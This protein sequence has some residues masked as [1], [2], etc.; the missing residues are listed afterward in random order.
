MPGSS[1]KEGG[2]AGCHLRRRSTQIENT[3]TISLATICGAFSR[4]V[5]QASVAVIVSSWSGQLAQRTR[6]AGSGVHSSCGWGTQKRKPQARAGLPIP[7][8]SDRLIQSESV[9]GRAHE[10][11]CIRFVWSGAGTAY[12]DGGAD[13]FS[14]HAIRDRHWHPKVLWCRSDRKTVRSASTH[15]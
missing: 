9:G 5:A 3:T 6:A 10:S 12:R 7:D 15:C 4:K 1:S 11:Q 8:W 2:A 14:R 13:A